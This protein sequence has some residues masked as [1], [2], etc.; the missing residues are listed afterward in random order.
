MGQALEDL[1]GIEEFTSGRSTDG[2]QE[3]QPFDPSEKRWRR[4]ERADECSAFNDR[5]NEVVCHQGSSPGRPGAFGRLS[6][7]S[8]VS[9]G[10]RA[11]GA[12]N[13]CASG[14]DAFPETSVSDVCFDFGS[15]FSLDFGSN[16][17]LDFGSNFS[18]DFGSNFS[19]DFGSNFSTDFG[20]NFSTDFGS[21]LSTDFGSGLAT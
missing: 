1:C 21:T 7:V 18:T 12:G 17:S 10:S 13:S 3:T 6:R 11:A 20:S 2:A 14:E 5:S 19:L 4:P 8:R 16:F 9:R 15:N